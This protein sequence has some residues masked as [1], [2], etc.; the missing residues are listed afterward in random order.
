GD[1]LKIYQNPFREDTRV[2]LSLPE[3]SGHVLTLSDALGRTIE[4][5]E[6]ADPRG[7]YTLGGTVAPG[8]YF[9][10]VAHNGQVLQT[11]KLLKI[12]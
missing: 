1:Y 6:V 9:A 4:T 11:V 2:L 5:V 7:E 12:E 8:I 10:T 3:G